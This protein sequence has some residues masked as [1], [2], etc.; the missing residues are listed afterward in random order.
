MWFRPR[1]G[2]AR[3]PPS[4]MGQGLAGAMARQ[5]ARPPSFFH[6][7]PLSSSSLV[8]SAEY[9]GD[10]QVF[11]YLENMESLFES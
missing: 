8:F 6:S 4:L 7:P 2:T 1:I 9:D 3:L 11:Y 5:E 10:F